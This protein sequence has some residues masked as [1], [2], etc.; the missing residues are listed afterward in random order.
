[1]PDNIFPAVKERIDNFKLSQ[2]HTPEEWQCFF[3][4]GILLLEHVEDRMKEYAIERMQKGIWSENSQHYRQGDFKA[5]PASQRLQPIL[6]A[7]L[8]QQEK[9]LC[10]LRFT[11][12]SSLSEEQKEFFSQWLS[13]AEADGIISQVAAA[14]ARI[15]TD[16]FTKE[17]WNLAKSFLEPFFDHPNDLLRA[18]SGAAFGEMYADGAENMPPLGK[19]MQEVKEWEIARPGFAGAFLG[20]LLM[21][22]AA[23]R[24]IE[25]GGI[26]VTDWILEIIAKRLT[27][28]PCVPFYNGIDFHAHE[29]L[30][31]NPQA[32]GK[33][34][35]FGAESVAA[36]A[37]TE[38]SRPIAGMQEHLE[39]L[40]SSSDNFVSR[41]CSWH[42]A[43]NYRFL[44]PEGVRRGY[45]QLAER[46]DVEIFL[47]FDPEEHD[48]RPYAATIYPRRASL[49]DDVAWKWIDRLIP[50]VLR[51]TMEDNDWPY[52]T[53]QIEPE[54][55]RFSY[56]AYIINLYG[57][58]EKNQWNRIWVKWPL[59]STK[60]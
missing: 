45:V 32:V 53:P 50:P 39:H 26:K 6:D 48:D 15:Q 2:I 20:Q 1:M 9:E 16:L 60:W 27:D 30:S 24:E 21:N 14:T 11:K 7:T 47:V 34:I 31:C 22:T 37:A 43:Y 35:D 13:Q 49:T 28:E 19:V 54:C 58:S 17:D 40:A 51:P 33:L 18:A 8:R 57:D 5:A 25:G 29:I 10:L 12:W 36:M 46:E 3:D 38:E 44:H 23:D 56:G 55:A 52:K 4:D 41:I 59:R 42:L